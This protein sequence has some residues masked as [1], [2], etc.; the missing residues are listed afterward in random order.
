V[1]GTAESESLR[2]G[3]RVAGAIGAIEGVQSVAQWVGRAP[4]GA[5]TLGTHYSE[6]EVE[7]GAVRG[8]EQ[9][10]I[11]R[12]IRATLAGERGAQFP[13]VTFAVNFTERMRRPSPVSRRR[14]RSTSTADRIWAAT[15]RPRPSG[16]RRAGRARRVAAGAARA[17]QS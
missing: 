3:Q 2:L 7:I 15:P 6:F 8:R 10:R 12:E 14:W 1:P 16:E 11:L 17:A 5:D 9:V 13:G 4:G